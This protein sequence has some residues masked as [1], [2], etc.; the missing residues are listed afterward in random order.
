MV[1]KTMIEVMSSL[2]RFY[3]LFYLMFQDEI[4]LGGFLHMYFSY[5]YFFQCLQW[6][7][8]QLSKFYFIEIC[9]MHV[10][11]KKWNCIKTFHKMFNKH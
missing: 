4:F 2:S 11:G 3:F 10:S 6:N 5:P 9:L 1:A 7:R 8:K